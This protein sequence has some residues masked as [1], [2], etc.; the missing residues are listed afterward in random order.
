MQVIAHR[1][2][3]TNAPENSMLAFQAAVDIDAFGIEFDVRLTADQIPVIFHHMHFSNRDL[4]G[5][6]ADYTYADLKRIELNCPVTHQT[7]HIPSLRD[8]LSAFADKLYLEIHVQ[9]YGPEVVPQM[10]EILKDYTDAWPRMEIISYEAAILLGFQKACCGI[11][12]DFLF[13]PERWMTPEIAL[14]LMAEKG[15]LANARAVHLFVEQ[16]TPESSSVIEYNGMEVK[17]CV[18]EHVATHKPLDANL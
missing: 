12:T 5:F 8:V 10:T 6:I 17:C 1:G 2:E 14:R 3:H 15:R 4:S 13:R 11:A 18:V 9:S 16:I 7:Y